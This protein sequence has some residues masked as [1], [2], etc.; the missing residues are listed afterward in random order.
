M[1]VHES[2]N[3]AFA[4]EMENKHAMM[5]A[6]LMKVLPSMSSMER[7]LQWLAYA[8]VESYDLQLAQVWMSFIDVNELAIT[9]PSATVAR[10][11]LL[12]E[13]LH[14]D[15]SMF[16]AA[17]RFAREQRTIPAQVVDVVFPPTQAVL[18]K[19]YGLK[20]C[21]GGLIS[22][23][24]APP[25]SSNHVLHTQRTARVSLV[26]LFFL[27]QRAHRDMMS[28]I[29]N[30]LKEAIE[31]AAHRNLLIAVSPSL[32]ET[33]PP[34]PRISPL[35]TLIPCRKEGNNL[36]L[37]DNPFARNSFLPDKPTLRLYI[38]IDGK[39]NVARLCQGLMMDIETIA[40]ALQTLLKL[41]RI[42]LLDTQGHI[43]DAAQIF[44]ESDL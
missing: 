40:P 14:L 8:I 21:T 7:L 17:K 23:E 5:V 33:S 24:V 10:N 9:R 41:H 16:M 32:T 11:P 18:L 34:A 28:A 6:Q 37:S 44:P 39:K 25:I 36:M 27:S 31:L 19:Q 26:T 29:T 35:A 13:Y 3:A 4:V 38:T 42:E 43:M 30:L 1:S 15:S 22:S 12:P 20:F 2:E